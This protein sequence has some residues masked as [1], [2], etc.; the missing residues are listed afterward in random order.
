MAAAEARPNRERIITSCL[1]PSARSPSTLQSHTIATRQKMKAII[2]LSALALSHLVTAAP[3]PVITARAELVPRQDDPALLGWV[4]T[5]GASECTPSSSAPH[6]S[7]RH[8]AFIPAAVVSMFWI[9][10]YPSRH[11]TAID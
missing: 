6:N 7:S 5:S 2:A 11:G 10:S 1:D 4:S 9:S 8:R 3:D